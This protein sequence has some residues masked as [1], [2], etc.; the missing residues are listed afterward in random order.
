MYKI[1]MFI[2]MLA[3]TLN[4]AT[5]EE[6]PVI[7]AVKI[8][9]PPVLDGRLDEPFWA[10]ARE[11]RDFGIAFGP[12][13]GTL[14]GDTIVK[15]AHDHTWLYF[16][17]DCANEAMRNLQ[18]TVKGHDKGAANDESLEIFLMP[19]A[20]RDMYFHYML[21]WGGA[22]DERRVTRGAREIGWNVP[23]RSAVD[24][25]EDGWSAEIALPLYLV[26]SYGDP[27]ALAF[28]I[29][30]NKRIANIDANGVVVSEDKQSSSLAPVVAGFHEPDK[31]LSLRLS[32][33]LRFSIPAQARI[34]TARIQSYDSVGKTV[35]YGVQCEIAGYTDQTGDYILEVLDQPINTQAAA[36]ATNIQ[37]KGMSPATFMLKIPVQTMIERTV[38]VMLK[39]AG[40]GEILQT[41]DIDDLSAL[42]IMDVYLDR[43]YYTTES[44]ALAI[45][46]V[47]LP[48]DVMR[49][50]AVVITDSD[51][52]QVGGAT[53]VAGVT[54][55]EIDL[56]LVNQGTEILTV[57]L[58]KDGRKY[59][60]REVKLI[61]RAPK[62]GHAWKIDKVNRVVLNNNKPFFAL[63]MCWH[64]EIDFEQYADAGFNLWF[65]WQKDSDPEKISATMAEAAQHGLV[66]IQSPDYFA[67][68]FSYEELFDGIVPETMAEE[69]KATPWRWS[70]NTL[71]LHVYLNQ[72][73]NMRSLTSTQ[74]T[75][76]FERGWHAHIPAI[77]ET[78]NIIKEKNNLASWFIFDE[79]PAD[80]VFEQSRFGREYYAM[81]H[82]ADGYHPVLV[83][84][85]SYIPEGDQ[86]VDWCDILVTD[87]Y[88]TPARP[89]MGVRSTVDFVAKITWM[90]YYRGEKNRQAC[91]QIP[92]GNVWSGFRKRPLTTAE[93]LCQ[94][95]MAVIYGANGLVYFAGPVYAEESWDALRE[96]C[97]RFK[98]IGPAA[99]SPLVDQEVE[100][101]IDIG[102]KVVPVKFDY[103]KD[104]YPAV[105]ARVLRRPQGGMLLLAANARSYPVDVK[106][107]ADHLSGEIEH[108]F[109]DRSLQA[110]DN[111]FTDT[112]EPLGVRAYAIPDLPEPVVLRVSMTLKEDQALEPELR[113]VRN[114]RP[115]NK[116]KLPNPG[117]EIST[118]RGWPDF[119]MPAKSADMTRMAG[120]PDPAWGV[121]SESSYEGQNCLRLAHP[122]N[123]TY[124]TCEPQ[125]DREVPYTFSVWLKASRPDITAWIYLPAMK[126]LPGLEYDYRVSKKFELT[127]EWKRYAVTALLPPRVGGGSSAFSNMLN[128]RILDTQSG[129]VVW[130]DAA[131]FEEGME[132][133][134][135][136]RK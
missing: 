89:E 109:P 18:P 10:E 33:D 90:T 94:S 25:R 112:F 106:F 42:N 121:V 16:G 11:H 95:Y 51:G 108:W 39:D 38:T 79:P 100:Y 28:N 101:E 84:Y 122:V 66:V 114:Y 27:D 34:E 126:R 129:D 15:V 99:V 54:H 44:C 119:W 32:A 74:R 12:G 96:V 134:E 58:N 88:W 55:A 19:D 81:L 80:R 92:V 50:A 86:Y 135:F 97:R 53:T 48:P 131:Q 30:R 14:S 56:T 64:R 82:E 21:G 63:G 117:F 8:D 7:T 67:E 103:W 43:N 132:P 13:K 20:A 104:T 85:S 102:D 31:F 124:T 125:H 118:I 2:T 22:K 23:W 116:N 113:Y 136:E 1:L 133:T 62:P 17:V 5:A 98:K 115:E 69:V 93:Q 47:G 130:A 61:K 83:N 6:Q 36:T 127:T 45:C 72:N 52:T 24:V 75:A 77:M 105:H 76:I 107:Q 40:T 49:D 110:A 3:V 128:I 29:C 73:K 9:A 59:F 4:L 123:W 68:G 87:P 71:G 60:S 46:A 78:V 120:T 91:W 70:G 26:A 57:A 65:N 37:F 35:F 111:A 41:V